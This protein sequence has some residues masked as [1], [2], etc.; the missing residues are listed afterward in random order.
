MEGIVVEQAMEQGKK[1]ME[2]HFGR[3]LGSIQHRDGGLFISCVE[4]GKMMA[5][6]WHPTKQHSATCIHFKIRVVQR[7]ESEPGY[8]AI[9]TADA[10]IFGAV[11]KYNVW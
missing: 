3:S 1:I 9:A 7:A 8:W 10:P 6:Y 11:T 5:A 2:A 4:G